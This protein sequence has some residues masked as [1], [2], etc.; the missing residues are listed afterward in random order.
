MGQWLDRNR[1]VL[2]VAVVV[3]VTTL[4][5]VIQMRRPEP[6]PL[7]LSTATPSPLPEATAT[8]PPLRIYVSGAV[9]NPDVYEVP[10][11]SIVKDALLAAGGPAEEADLDRINLAAPLAD[12]QH[13][14]VPHLDEEELP[15]DLPS[16][17]PATGAKVNINTAD[18]PT[19]E[20]LPGIGPSLA[21]RILDYRQT[22]GPF[23]QS[24]DI[25][26][27][28]GIGPGIF[29]KIEELITTE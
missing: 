25:M 26:N 11:D 16:S 23:T 7:I 2:F 19:L 1:V 4:V 12:G 20:T 14:Y 15:V 21:Q 5:I 28:S 13:I 10:A 27:V 18:A 17:Q 29:A 6:E 8:P 3:L 24:Q 22:N 9:Q